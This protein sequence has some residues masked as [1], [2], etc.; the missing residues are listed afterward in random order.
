MD[1][2][3]KAVMTPDPDDGFLVTFPDVPEA[4]THGQTVAEALTS[5]REALGF[6]LR[7]RIKDNQP[8]PESLPTEGIDVYL[9][10]NDAL[11]MAVIEAFSASGMSKSE[12][13]RRLGRRETEARRILDPYHAT[14]LPL[15]E[16]ALS[17]LGK[18][19]LISVIDTKAA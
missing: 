16:A 8:L 11:K 14:G 3:Y 9:S 4:I 7:A 5:A 13:A 2:V 18:T 10:P 17:A 19:I 1:Y 12:L 15:L 6:A